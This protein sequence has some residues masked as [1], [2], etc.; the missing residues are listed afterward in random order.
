[1]SLAAA[2]A[3]TRLIVNDIRIRCVSSLSRRGSPETVS[4]GVDVSPRTPAAAAAA[5]TADAAVTRNS[6]TAASA[7]RR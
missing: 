4:G 1:M 7:L 3:V 2:M 5:A 6:T